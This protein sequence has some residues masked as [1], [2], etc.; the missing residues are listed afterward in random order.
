[1]TYGAV[2]LPPVAIT[3]GGELFGE[4]PGKGLNVSYL[5]ELAFRTGGRVN[6]AREELL[7]EKRIISERTPLYPPFLLAA[8][9]LILLEAFVRERGWFS[10][11]A[12]GGRV[13]EA[14]QRTREIGSYGVKRRV[15][16]GKR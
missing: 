3:L 8:A 2:K 14:P 13:V 9:M 7:R 11:R 1:M 4:S 16:Q 15:N 12:R 6:P 5:Q 10:A